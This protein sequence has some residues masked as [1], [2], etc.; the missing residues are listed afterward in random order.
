MAKKKKES[1]KPTGLGI[2]RT[3]GKITC[4]WKNYSYETQS[5][6]WETKVG[7][8]VVKKTPSISAGA[9]EKSF[10][11]SASDYCP[12]N[13]KPILDSA[14]FRVK[15]RTKDDD[16][17]NYT[18]SDWSKWESI[19][20]VKPVN[21]PRI[22]I[23]LGG[24]YS[25]V[26]YVN[27]ADHSSRKEMWETTVQYQSCLVLD[28][29]YTKGAD[30]PEQDWTG[31]SP[32]VYGE[33]PQLWPIWD[34]VYSQVR[35]EFNTG[36]RYWADSE[37]GRIA[38]ISAAI[39]N[40]KNP[41]RWFRARVCGPGGRGSWEYGH[42]SYS[43]PNEVSHPKATLTKNSSIDGYDVSVDFDIAYSASQP[44]DNIKIEYSI[45]VPNSD[46]TMSAQNWT[47]ADIGGGG[48]L[49]L[50][51]VKSIPKNS[52]SKYDIL[53]NYYKNTSVSGVLFQIAGPIPNDNLIYIRIVR[54][55]DIR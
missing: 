29:G 20:F 23:S 38:A 28:S 50:R 7:N 42:I 31:D 10:S 55:I 36:E 9:S 2:A 11:L 52:K 3:R 53:Q 26:F 35:T 30:I 17:Y 47:P 19:N 18:M 48:L 21:P 40:D 1:N 13:K 44:V 32:G 16:K 4:H 39:A 25:P 46:L 49:A 54:C 34:S 5:M 24:A 51:E 33:K 43:K 8:K 15:G 27:I 6:Q 45:S 22:S 14:R 37:S 12:Y 41:V